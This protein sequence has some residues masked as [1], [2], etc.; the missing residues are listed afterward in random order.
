[1]QPLTN[2]KPTLGRVSLEVMVDGIFLLVN[3]HQPRLVPAA[4]TDDRHVES[5]QRRSSKATILDPDPGYSASQEDFPTLWFTMYQATAIH[6]G[7]DFVLD[8]CD[9]L[10]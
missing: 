8:V 7:C 6:S 4:G 1:M 3:E 2:W 9:F 5:R 10:N